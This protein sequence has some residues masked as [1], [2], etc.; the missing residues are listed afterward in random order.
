MTRILAAVGLLAALGGA[1]CAAAV[2]EGLWV[3]RGSEVYNLEPGESVQFKLDFE[4]LPVRAWILSVDGGRLPC[5]LNVLRLADRS[6]LYQQNDEAVHRVRVPWGRGETV[7]I[8][9]TA[10]RRVGGSYTVKFLAPP[11]EEAPLAYGYDVNR[12]LEALEDDRPGAAEVHL[13]DAII[14]APEDAGVSYLLMASLARNRG[15]MERAAGLLD[16]ALAAGLPDDLAHVETELRTQLAKVRHRLA[17][18]LIEAD[19]LLRAG[20]G[21]AAA[22]A[23][24]EAYL[25]EPAGPPRSD[26]ETCEALRRLGQARQISGEI[27]PAQDALDRALATAVDRG[28]KAL[29]YHRLGLLQ[30]DL[31]NRDQAR[32]AFA[33]ARDQGLPPGLAAEVDSLIT[34]LDE[35]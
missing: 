9:L 7:S 8:T 12:A 4:V 31:G 17:P 26:W 29:V 24:I 23:A 2:P 35:E 34:E 11:P 28:Q 19:R 10:N 16:M 15:E 18:A 1:V 13:R 14:V 27:V 5:D 6:L 22:A 30:L 33:A 32:R 21:A 3:P 25:E 20:D